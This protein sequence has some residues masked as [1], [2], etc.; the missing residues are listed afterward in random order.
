MDFE[1]YNMLEVS[2]EEQKEEVKIFK[3]L[4]RFNKTLPDTPEYETLLKELFGDNIGENSQIMPPLSGIKLN[5]IK[6][7]KN[8]FINTN[9]LAMATGGITIE[10]EVL[11]AP[12]VQLLT[13]N[14]GEYNRM[15]V[16]SK[17]IHIRTGA[18]IGA[19]A[20]VLPG[21]TI[22]RH[23]IVG[24]ASVVTKD[25]GDCEVVAGVPAKL[26]KTLDKDKFEE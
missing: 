26:I 22:G 1:V 9:F 4:H 21:V 14:H 25:V 20:T 24:A 18:W 10:D 12:N 13:G 5:K 15:L 3:I 6:I 19:G 2:E 16:M 7:G 11:I 17:P 8:V 23:A